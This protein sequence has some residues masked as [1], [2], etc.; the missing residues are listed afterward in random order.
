MNVSKN[1]SII[2]L[3]RYEWFIYVMEETH[4]YVILDRASNGSPSVSFV[5]VN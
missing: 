3:L 5:V 2:R 4:V 1:D